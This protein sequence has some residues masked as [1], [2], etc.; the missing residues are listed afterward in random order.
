M[1]SLLSQLRTFAERKKPWIQSHPV[2]FAVYGMSAFVFAEY[3]ALPNTSLQVLRTHHPSITA[4]MEQ[5]I[6]EAE[7]KGKKLVLYKRWVPLSKISPNLIHAVIVSEDGTFYSHEGVDWYE[8][9]ESI[10]KNIERGK[11]ARGGSTIS[12]QLSKNLY[13][14]TSKD[15]IR[16]LKELIITLRMERILSKRRILELYLNLIEWGNGVFGAEAAAQKYFHK[17]ASELTRE[18]AA[19]LAA[20]IP[21]PRRYSVTHPSQYILKRESTILSRMSIRGF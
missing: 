12:Q 7:A 19:L 18:E 3:L 9:E 16:K 13:L 5:R 14:S 10:K 20:V 2:R 6:D 21:N 15:P 17:P 1:D 8:V 11:A 4:V